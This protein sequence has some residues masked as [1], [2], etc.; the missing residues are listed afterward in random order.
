MRYHPSADPVD[1]ATIDVMLPTIRWPVR[2][3][4]DANK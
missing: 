4:V 2:P 1:T 3:P